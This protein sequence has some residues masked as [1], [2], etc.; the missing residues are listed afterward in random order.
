MLP[1]TFQ[2]D[3]IG[4]FLNQFGGMVGR[5]SKVT[6][7]DVARLAG[8]APSTV[9]MALANHAEIAEETR[10]LIREAAAKLRYTPNHAARSMRSELQRAVGVVIPH[11]SAHVFSHPYFMDIL[12]GITEVANDHDF[13]VILSTAREEDQGESAYIKMLRAQRVDGVILASAAL[14]DRHVMELALSGYPFVFLGRYPLNQNITAV[15]VDDIGGAGM[16]TS[17]LLAHGYRSI[18]HITGPLAHLSAV[19]RRDGFRNALA[20]AGIA[21]RDEDLI[22][23]DYSEASGRLAAQ[24]LLERPRL[25]EAIFAANDEMAFGVLDVFRARG[26]RIP[27]DVALVG[28]DDLAIARV[29]SPALTTI[30]QPIVQ[31]GATAAERLIALVEHQEAPETQTI[32][33]VTLTIRDSCG[34]E[35]EIM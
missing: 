9:S 17:H 3:D 8:V 14:F 15:G 34:P 2:T 25:P 24:H 20:R 18:V 16:L 30:H 10:Q 31:L 13:V 5:Q 33:P 27:E 22:E 29:M 1:E 4:I 6:I 7:R 12:G 35:P 23:G 26:L 32:V 19:D 28:F 21:S 11:S